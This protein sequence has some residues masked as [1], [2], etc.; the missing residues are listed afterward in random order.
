VDTVDAMPGPSEVQLGRHLR[1]LRCTL[2]LEVAQLAQRCGLDEQVIEALELG[3]H[4]ADV[5]TLR[6]L[7]KGLGVRVG[8]IFALWERQ[9]LR[10]GSDLSG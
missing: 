4:G 10:Q 5:A 2:G 6:T 1:E 3:H 7:A 9:A 8:V